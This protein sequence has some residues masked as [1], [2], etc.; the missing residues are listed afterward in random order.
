MKTF[1]R[2]RSW[3]KLTSVFLHFKPRPKLFRILTSLVLCEKGTQVSE[4]TYA[5]PWVLQRLLGCDSFSWVDGQHL[6]DQ[7]FRLRSHRVP[8]WGRKLKRNTHALFEMMISQLRVREKQRSHRTLQLWSAGRV[9]AGPRPRTEGIQPK[10]CRG[11]HLHT[12]PMLCQRD[13]KAGEEAEADKELTT[14]PDVYRFTVRLLPQ[15]LGGQVARGS[16]KSCRTQTGVA[17][18]S[19]ILWEIKQLCSHISAREKWREVPFTQTKLETPTKQDSTTSSEP[20][21]AAEMVH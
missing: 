12:R 1:W 8:L 5:D 16:C 18:S 11:S 21:A 6:V 17:F 13:K 19:V 7:I 20:A 10:G 14:C 15:H 3:S 2:V 4:C 9:C